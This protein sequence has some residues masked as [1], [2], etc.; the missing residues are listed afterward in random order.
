[1]SSRV[2]S[3]G[4]RRMVIS[5]SEASS[6]RRAHQIPTIL[7]LIKSRRPTFYQEIIVS[8]AFVDINDNTALK[9]ITSRPP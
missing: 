7:P 6:L 1:M 3:P 5:H 4:E 8:P 2:R 9:G